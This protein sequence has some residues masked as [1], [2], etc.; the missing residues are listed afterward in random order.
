MSVPIEV[1]EFQC[2]LS[3]KSDLQKPI[4]PQGSR[5]QPTKS[6]KL[7]RITQFHVHK[8]ILSNQG[9][10]MNSLWDLENG[11]SWAVNVLRLQLL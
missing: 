4:V 5:I 10:L 6:H 9:S 3:A 11:W 8:T 1:T 7:G 2:L